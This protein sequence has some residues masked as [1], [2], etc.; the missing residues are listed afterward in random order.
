MH[1]CIGQNDVSLNSW[2]ESLDDGQACHW[3]AQVNQ[4]QVVWFVACVQIGGSTV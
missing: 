1:V 4:S 2:L 3:G